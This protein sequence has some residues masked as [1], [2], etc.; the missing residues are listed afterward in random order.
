MPMKRV[1]RF[2]IATVA[3]V[4]LLTIHPLPAQGG[5]QSPAGQKKTTS[6]GGNT[7]TNTN[8]KNNNNNNNTP[9]P[10]PNPEIA[11]TKAEIVTDQDALSTLV[12][13]LTSDSGP[14][15]PAGKESNL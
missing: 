13:K 3:L 10:P 9:A 4:G 5:M 1:V 12:K 8:N 2:A 15:G 11:L 14:R 6:K 7:N